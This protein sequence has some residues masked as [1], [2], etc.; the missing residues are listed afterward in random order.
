VAVPDELLEA[1]GD[2]E[3]VVVLT[4]PLHERDTQSLVER[5][6]T[7][8]FAPPPDTAQDLID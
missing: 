3:S 4:G 1:A 5:L 8:V 2:R 7:T 6:G